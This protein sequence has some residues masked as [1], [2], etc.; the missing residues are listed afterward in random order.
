MRVPMTER[1][2]RHYE[3]GTRGISAQIAKLSDEVERRHLR[4]REK[5]ADSRNGGVRDNR[6]TPRELFDFLNAEFGFTLDVAATSD[7]A[8]CARFFSCPILSARIRLA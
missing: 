2:V 8:L 6:S 7:N 1:A 4:K 5:V 3:N